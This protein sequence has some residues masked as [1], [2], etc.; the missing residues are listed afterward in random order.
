MS[1]QGTA[2]GAQEAKFKYVN[3]RNRGVVSHKYGLGIDTKQV[4]PGD[5]VALTEASCTT[6]LTTEPQSPPLASHTFVD[7]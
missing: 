7:T 5:H 1:R 4:E 2:Q 3:Y 6:Q